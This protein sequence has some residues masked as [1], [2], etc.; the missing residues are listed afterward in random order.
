M[1]GVVAMGLKLEIG[2]CRDYWWSVLWLC[3]KF[4]S[5]AVFFVESGSAVPLLFV[6]LR[7]ALP[8]YFQ[9]QWSHFEPRVPSR[10]SASSLSILQVTPADSYHSWILILD[11]EH[12]ILEAVVDSNILVGECTRVQLSCLWIVVLA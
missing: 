11:V 1:K 4:G 10:L 7:S 6:D 12:C 2:R 9:R 3:G 5:I 8:F